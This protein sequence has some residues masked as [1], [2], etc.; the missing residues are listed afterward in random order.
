MVVFSIL[1]ADFSED[2]INFV[3]G[4][5]IEEKVPH[6]AKMLEKEHYP[7]DWKIVMEKTAAMMLDIYRYP[8]LQ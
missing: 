5:K 2:F 8:I 1:C 4:L 3:P 6:F 7:L